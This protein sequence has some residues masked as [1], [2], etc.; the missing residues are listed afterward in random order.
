MCLKYRGSSTLP[1]RLW[2]D[3]NCNAGW[4]STLW[5]HKD[6]ICDL[7]ASTCDLGI[8]AHIAGDIMVMVAGT[9]P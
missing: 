1:D 3:V 4:I 6:Y 8:T 2:Y 7:R 5:T 9:L